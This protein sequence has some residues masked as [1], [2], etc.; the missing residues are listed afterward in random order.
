MEEG[1]ENGGYLEGKDNTVDR[2]AT[3]TSADLL[4]VYDE[5]V[6]NCASH[7]TDWVVDS[8]ASL[9]V[10]KRKEF[11]C[12]YTPGNFG[13]LRMGN[14]GMSPVI[15]IGDVCLK[16]SNGSELLLR[17]VKHS[18]DIRL[19]LISVGK[20][21]DD[22]FS[23]NFTGGEWKLLKGSLIVAHG[24]KFSSN[25]YLMQA[26]ISDRVNVV[27]NKISPDLW[28]RR[29]S[30]ISEKGLNCLIRNNA[31]FGVSTAKLDKCD[32]CMAGKQNRVSFK[33]H[34]PHR[35]SS[36]LELIYSYVCGP[37]KVQSLGGASYFVTFIDDYSR[38]LW[39]YVL[40]TKNQVLD[41]VQG[42]SSF[43]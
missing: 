21:D 34:P 42:I 25:L 10:A 17:G 36:L 24:K 16:T 14:D 30:H 32:H 2:F 20:L 33:S 13:V 41:K 6:I 15:G 28:H 8:G 12:S 38:K 11:F 35:K 5:D 29:L 3:T 40:K 19:N 7:D 37:L 31:I 9:H 4:V 43:C 18:P 39:V 26:S 27:D 1:Q 22:G 23:N